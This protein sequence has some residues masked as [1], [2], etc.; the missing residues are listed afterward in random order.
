M[1]PQRREHGNR[2][3]KVFQYVISYDYVEARIARKL[4]QTRDDI[5]ETAAPSSRLDPN[6]MRPSARYLLE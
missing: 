6:N 2:T 1:Q 4:R 3:L 5:W